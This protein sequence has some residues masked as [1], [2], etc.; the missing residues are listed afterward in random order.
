[1]CNLYSMMSNKDAIR[2]F[3][4]FLRTT[5]GSDNLETQPDIFANGFGPIVRATP[6]GRELAIAR[7]G[8]PSSEDA[9]GTKNYDNGTTNIRRTWL[10][11]WKPYLDIENRCVVPATSF[12]EPDQVGKTFKNYW[13]A[14]DETRPLFFFAGIWTPQWTSVR[15]VKEG[16]TTS[17][18]YGFLTTAP[19]AE[20]GQYHDKAMPVILRTPEEVETWFTLPVK[21]IKEFQKSKTLPDGTLKIVATG[22]KWDPPTATPSHLKDKPAQAPV[23]APPTQPDLF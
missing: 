22:L 15:K 3:A 18:L 13:F 2:E 20:V 9:I 8:M 1:M 6:E 19:N 23:P 11:H 12:A 5:S 4:R 14:L 10:P 7:W 21:D 16:E 17:D